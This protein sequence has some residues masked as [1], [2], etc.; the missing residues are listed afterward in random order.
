MR[1]SR[2][3]ALDHKSKGF[4]LSTAYPTAARKVEVEAP[5]DDAIGHVARELAVHGLSYERRVPRHHVGRRQH[6]VGRC[7]DNREGEIH[8]GVGNFVL[9]RVGVC[10]GVDELDGD[11]HLAPLVDNVSPHR[12]VVNFHIVWKGV[13][14]ARKLV[15]VWRRF[16]VGRHAKGERE[17]EWRRIVKDDWRG[18]RRVRG[19]VV[20]R[21]G[22][23][24][25][26]RHG[27]R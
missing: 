22:G 2:A 12:S 15:P 27:R 9:G 19:H 4:R 24:N 1:E 21:G 20:D 17:W 10:D 5:R 18:G 16:E 26:M 13:V 3:V 8:V 6:L 23:C 14:V 7:V 25:G 11:A